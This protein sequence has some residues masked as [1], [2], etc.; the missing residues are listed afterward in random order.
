MKRVNQSININ[1][2][3]DVQRELQNIRKL[4]IDIGYYNGSG[5]PENV[6]Y[7][8]LGAIYRD[9]SSGRIYQKVSNNGGRSGWERLGIEPGTVKAYAGSTIPSGWLDCDGEAISRT[10]NADLFNAI[11]TTWG[12]GDGSTTFNKPDFRSAT[13]RGVGTPTIFTSNDAVTLAQTIDDQM[14]G[15]YHDPPG[16]ATDFYVKGGTGQIDNIKGSASGIRH[17]TTTGVPVEDGTNGTP[18]TGLETT[19]KARGVYWIIKT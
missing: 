2:F 4:F 1:T 11:G 8:E 7:A 17:Q 9:T 12:A 14:Q 16:T 18:R 15:H 5:S 19:G 6:V 10:V 3:E 13:L